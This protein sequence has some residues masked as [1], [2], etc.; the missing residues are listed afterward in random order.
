MYTRLLEKQL[1]S[2]AKQYLVVSVMGP[3]QSGKS[4]LVKATF[5]NKPYINLEAPNS[6]LLAQTDP[7]GFLAQYPDGALSR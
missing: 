4:T 1:V 3:R 7:Q 2:L 5:P 6:R